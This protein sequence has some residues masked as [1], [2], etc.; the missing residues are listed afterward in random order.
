MRV[1]RAEYIQKQCLQIR[2]RF[3][4]GTYQ[5][6]SFSW[7]CFTNLASYASKLDKGELQPLLQSMHLGRHQM[8]T[9]QGIDTCSEPQ[10][11]IYAHR[12]RG[13]HKHM[14]NQQWLL[15][16]AHISCVVL[17]AFMMTAACCTHRDAHKLLLLLF[18]AINFNLLGGKPLD[19]KNILFSRGGPQNTL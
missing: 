7:V 13:L 18:F 1:G 19:I 17:I 9:S 8:L 4:K 6:N 3:K 5:N 16:H 15:G 10:T 11:R 2:F 14:H 12:Q